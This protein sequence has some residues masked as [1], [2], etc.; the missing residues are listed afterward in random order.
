[1][2]MD[3]FVDDVQSAIQIYF[4]T[5]VVSHDPKDALVIQ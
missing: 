5:T 3:K 4:N 2:F 1:M